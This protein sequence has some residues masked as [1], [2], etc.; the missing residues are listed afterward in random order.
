MIVSHVMKVNTHWTTIRIDG[1]TTKGHEGNIFCMTPCTF[2]AKISPRM[3]CKLPESNKQ[4]TAGVTVTSVVHRKY[5][6][7]LVVSLSAIF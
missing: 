2:G 1:N 3:K 7:V 6:A 4:A 5:V